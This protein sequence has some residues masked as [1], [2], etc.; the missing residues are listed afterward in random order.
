MKYKH[1]IYVRC[2]N[3][4]R[5]FDEDEITDPEINIESD[6]R[7]WDVL[8]FKCPYCHKETTSLRRG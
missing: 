8:T 7:G 1:I 3:C 5:E 4:E 2:K 6:E